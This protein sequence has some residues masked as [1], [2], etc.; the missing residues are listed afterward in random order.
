MTNNS[1][2]Y[3][4]TSKDQESLNIDPNSVNLSRDSIDRESLGKKF[5][6]CRTPKIMYPES[7]SKLPS[8]F[9]NPHMRSSLGESLKKRPRL[10]SAHFISETGK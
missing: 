3:P 4:E 5:F 10:T 1:E 8:V 6:K 2:R 7:D 9:R